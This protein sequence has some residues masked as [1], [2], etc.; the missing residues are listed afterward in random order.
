[1]GVLFP[2]PPVVPPLLL[3]LL[4]L[5]T[6]GNFVQ[7]SC[8]YVLGAYV[9]RTYLEAKHRPAYIVWETFGAGT[10]DGTS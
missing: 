9:G 10:G 5:I 1:M 7:G 6:L 4:L 2:G 3:G 8:S